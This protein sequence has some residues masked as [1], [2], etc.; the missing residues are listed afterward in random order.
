MSR[1]DSAIRRSQGSSRSMVVSAPCPGR[2]RTP[3]GI[4]RARR[5]SDAAI[6]S[7][8][9]P[10]R[11]VRP[12]VPA[13]RTSPASRSAV[14]LL[15]EADR[16]LRV[17]RRMQHV[18]DEVTD[19]DLLAFHQFAG[20]SDRAKVEPV[21]VAPVEPV[22]VIGMDRQRRLRCIHQRGVVEDV[23]DVPVR[24]RDEV[25]AQAVGGGALHQRARL[26]PCRGPRPARRV[27]RPSHTM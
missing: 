25:Q 9:P 15:V 23:I 2:T 1:P 26:H 12:Y 17:P 3:G 21:V 5:A 24:V 7:S 16:S 11:S 4:S 10:G 14:P 6:C 19:P 22:G 13:K 20:G 18:E 8:L 27:E